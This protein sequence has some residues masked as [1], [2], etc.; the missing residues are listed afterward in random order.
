METQDDNHSK[1]EEEVSLE[2][3]FICAIEELI[4]SKKKNKLLREQLLKFEEV[5]KSTKNKV[6]KTI[7]YSKQL[8]IELKTKLQEIRTKEEILNK[9]LNEKQ[10]TCNILED[11]IIQL[12]GKQEK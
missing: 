5:I 12:K 7:S 10:Q 11:E 6:S 2:E 4:K 3:E 1:Y 9:E 8:I